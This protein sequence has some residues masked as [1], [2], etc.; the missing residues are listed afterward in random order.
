MVGPSGA[1]WWREWSV[2]V[3]ALRCEGR[4][5]GTGNPVEKGN[6]VWF[7]A[8]V[9]AHMSRCLGTKSV[10]ACLDVL[11]APAPAPRRGSCL[12]KSAPR[13]SADGRAP[14][15][16]MDLNQKD[17]SVTRALALALMR[18]AGEYLGAI[19]EDEALVH[20]QR[21][22]DALL[23]PTPARSAQA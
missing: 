10:G 14:D 21:A 19:D 11:P 20:L 13:C 12:A 4:G 23:K 8:G 22:I 16:D 5:A 2:L 15:G 9:S 17:P 18:Q 1:P 3:P 6:S 7:H